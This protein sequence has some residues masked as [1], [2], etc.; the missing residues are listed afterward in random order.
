MKIY[1]SRY[2]NPEVA[3]R[4]AGGELVPLGITQGNARFL[5]YRLAG[6]ERRLAPDREM[7]GLHERSVFEP[8]MRAKLDRLGAEA[9]DLLHEVS[10]AHGGPPWGPDPTGGARRAGRDVVMLCFEDVR[11]PDVWCHRLIVAAWLTEHFGIAVPELED[12]SEIKAPKGS[13]PRK[14][15]GETLD[16][17]VARIEQRALALDG[18]DW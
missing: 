7:L 8:L 12:P 16:E 1:T 9:M 11:R 4:V 5:K 6:N 15:E 3:T 14:R 10:A 13:K 18:L 2:Y 17:A